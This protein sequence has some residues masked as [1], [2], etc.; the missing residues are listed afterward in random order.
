M[1]EVIFAILFASMAITPVVVI[2]LLVIKGVDRYEPE[3]W[4][5]L[6]GCFLWGVFGATFFAILGNTIGMAFVQLGLGGYASEQAMMSTTASF[7]AP[8]V[9]ESTKGIFLLF[10]W[11][12]SSVWL[13]ELDGPLDG[14]IYGG[15]VGLGFTLTEDVLYVTSATLQQGAV[16]GEAVFILR[17]IMGG[18]GHAT[19][20]A[21]TGLGVGIAAESR[22]LLVKLIAPVGGWMAAVGL[23]FLHNFLVTF[24]LAGGLG[25]VAKLLVFWTFDIVFFVLLYVLVLRDRAIIIRGLVDEVGR[26]LHPREFKRTISYSMV[27]PLW[28]ASSLL[29]SPGGYRRAR[30]KQLDLVK[31]A[32]VKQRLSRGENEQAWADRLRARIQ[33]AN[34]ENVFIGPR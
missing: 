21:M 29:G 1:L 28:N 13:K 10:V 30:Q 2:Y 18:L 23:H 12:L 15:M 6:G 17:T 3:P 4:W 33:K 5:L 27:I 32:F 34:H 19:F 22:S 26:L 24:W 31:L 20:T 16:V 9:E 7:V 8:P 14:A 25:V 11:A